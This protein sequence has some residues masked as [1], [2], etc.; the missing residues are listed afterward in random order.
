MRT[1]P[2]TVAGLSGITVTSTTTASAA[3]SYD[4]RGTRTSRTIGALTQRFAWDTHAG[5][6]VVLTDG[7]TSYLY[8]DSGTPIEQVNPAGV[9]LY[10]GH[11]Q[12]G[13][14]RLLSLNTTAVDLHVFEHDVGIKQASRGLNRHDTPGGPTTG[15]QVVP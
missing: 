5:L 11:D 8:D 6:P 7:T 12:Y 15:S 2:V 1:T 10:F 4:G 9:A 14:T 13:S 3:Y